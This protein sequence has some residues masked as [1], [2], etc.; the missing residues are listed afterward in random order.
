MRRRE[1][2]LAGLDE[3]IRQHIE[4]EIEDSIARG[5]TPGEARRAA[6]RKFGNVSRVKE[7][8]RDVWTA[9]WLE[10]F[11]QD[12]RYALRT[13][14]KSPGFTAVAAIT[15]ALAIG[16]NTAIFSV[17]YAV[18]LRPLPFANPD[19]LVL[20]FDSNQREQDPFD[21]LSYADFEE[22]REQNRAFTDVA[23]NQ[24]HQLTLTG[25]GEPTVLTT[26]VVTPELFSV[27][28]VKPLAGR[29]FLPEDGKRGA[30]PVVI[31]SENLWRSRFGADPNLVGRSISL[32]K[33]PFT[34]V[35]IMPASF[36]SL[37]LV[38][39][40]DIWIPIVQ[41]PMFGKWM[42]RAGGHW[43]RV[44]ARLKPGVSLAQAQ[45]EMNTLSA[46]L[47]KEFPAENSGWSI[48]VEPLQESIV[49]F[50]RP[51]LLVLLGA[52]GLVLLIACVNIANLMLSRASARAREIAVRIALGAGRKRIIR[53]LLTESAVLGLVGGVIGVLL[54]YG[55]VHAL[56]S[57]LPADLPRVQS[58]RVDARV[59]AFALFLSVAASF[60][61]GL[62]PS[63]FAA[64]SNLLTG[65]KEASGRAG[66]S[67]GPRRARAFLAI[68]EIALA[69]VLLVAAGLL[70]RSFTMLT[71]VN[72]GFNAE[73]VVKA[74]I[75]L[76]QFEYSTPQQWTS[77][78][79]ALLDRL[80]AEPGLQ[81][82][83]M[84]VP[85]PL[86]EGN[87]NL[88]LKIAGN[89][90]LPPGISLTADFT[91]VSPGY[92]RVMGIPLLRGRLFTEQDSES[93]PRVTVISEALA[94]RYF[95]GQDPTGRQLIFGFPPNGNVSREIVGIVGDVRDAALNQ[96]PS[97][98]MYVPFDQ[99]PFW[100]G[101]IVV[102]SSLGAASVAGS[103][104]HATH[105]ID[106]DLPVTDIETLPETLRASVSQER[107]RTLLLGL[108]GVTALLLAAVGIFGVIS[109]SVARRTR[110]LGI[111]MALGAT[112]GRV[113]KLV[114]TESA[115][116]VLV[117][118]VL[119]II[120]ALG[121]TRFLSSLLFQV[122]A[123]DPLTFLGVAALLSL[124][125][126]FACY[127]PARRAMR[128]DPLEALRYE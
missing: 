81:N 64:D 3:E 1:R 108:F 58:I 109:Y 87:V 126:L 119:G 114:L 53:Q 48:H 94:R 32:D 42:S 57:F 116:L 7:E 15:L 31:V 85:L 22:C 38:E 113:L 41:D 10:Q 96:A 47:A 118:L 25:V 14:R 50:A 34:V 70:L 49:G 84:V 23:A 74:D 122:H 30:A 78:S 52:V 11:W 98:M 125:A 79:D 54:A 120:G 36:R 104:R 46:R 59:L 110:E 13:L 4:T 18:L 88:N 2:M 123:A 35:G 106:K 66:E 45:A 8:T 17:V 91:S 61:F 73:D 33:R 83:A 65:L 6:L 68:S 77:F 90:P 111:R 93:G 63:I 40:E 55:G 107:F 27:L 112:P 72:P 124:V 19:R 75:S 121:L 20:V 99:A 29:T 80:Q 82:S 92:F 62:A 28:G 102:K 67:G 71:S 89:P 76:P 117:G 37:L 21:G 24:E 127:V 86:D 128:V 51:A 26:N 44:I 103:I 12:V 5:M 95:P 43:M 100:G 105:E 39:H 16:A 9:V 56:S 60:L 115:R 69:M 97:P 101:Q